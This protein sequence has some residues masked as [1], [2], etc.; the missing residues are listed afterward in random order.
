MAT[1]VSSG[2]VL[3]VACTPGGMS[4]ISCKDQLDAVQ[5]MIKSG[6]LGRYS[7]PQGHYYG[8]PE[9]KAALEAVAQCVADTRERIAYDERKSAG[10]EPK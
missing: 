9:H 5:S 7:G 10:G 2:S 4:A 8:S 3:V 6:S 1:I